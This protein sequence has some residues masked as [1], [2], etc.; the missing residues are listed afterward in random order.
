[1]RIGSSAPRSLLLAGAVIG[2]FAVGAAAQH[3][4]RHPPQRRLPPRRR[5]RRAHR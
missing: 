1:M 4:P 3:R 2:V 5:F